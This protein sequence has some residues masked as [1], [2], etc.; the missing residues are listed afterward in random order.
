MGVETSAPPVSLLAGEGRELSLS[1]RRLAVAGMVGEL[2]GVS[3]F[4]RDEW[5]RRTFQGRAG[6][7]AMWVDGNV[8]NMALRERQCRVER[9]AVYGRR[10]DAKD[11]RYRAGAI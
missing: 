4:D 9:G 10:A 3:L 5:G 7:G 1:G 6:E 11:Q 8:V 2:A